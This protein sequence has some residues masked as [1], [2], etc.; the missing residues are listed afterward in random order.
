MTAA[1]PP[2][3]ATGKD[4]ILAIPTNADQSL[5]LLPSSKNTGSSSMGSMAQL[6]VIG[7]LIEHTE[8]SNKLM[9]MLNALKQ[10]RRINNPSKDVSDDEAEEPVPNVSS[11]FLLGQN[12]KI[13]D[14]PRHTPSSSPASGS[15]PLPAPRPDIDIGLGWTADDAAPVIDWQAL[16][17]S[18]NQSTNPKQQ[19]SDYV[20]YLEL[21][22]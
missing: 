17:S 11:F 14:K 15:S 8:C 21:G 7:T 13:P 19:K 6:D 2:P 3:A 5:V 10:Q 20:D 18:F 16:T 9:K 1:G 12:D 22:M 4:P